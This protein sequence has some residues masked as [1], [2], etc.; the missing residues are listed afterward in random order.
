MRRENEE[1]NL[2]IHFRDWHLGGRLPLKFTVW[3]F[4][5][6]TKN[7][8]K[9][10]LRDCIDCHQDVSIAHVSGCAIANSLRTRN[11]YQADISNSQ[12]GWTFPAHYWEHQ[13]GWLAWVSSREKQR[14]EVG[15]EQEDNQFPWGKCLDW[16]N[17]SLLGVRKTLALKQIFAFPKC[18]L[19]LDTKKCSVVYHA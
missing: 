19:I 16:F 12:R 5:S 2:Y 14:R 7:D 13:G 17:R 18:E 11:C 1:T 3:Q 9:L 8:N 15:G 6:S 4:V 10:P